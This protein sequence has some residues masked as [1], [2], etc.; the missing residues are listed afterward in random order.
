MTE[1]EGEKYSIYIYIE[2]RERERDR[3]KR[4]FLKYF[5]FV[6]ELCSWGSGN[7]DQ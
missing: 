7:G 3:R 1:R 2:E 5:I 4:V 6:D